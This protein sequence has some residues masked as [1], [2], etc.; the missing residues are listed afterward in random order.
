[1]E[2]CMAS[3]SEHSWASALRLTLH[4]KSTANE[5]LGKFIRIDSYIAFDLPIIGHKIRAKKCIGYTS[6]WRYFSGNKKFSG[7]Y[8]TLFN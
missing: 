1:M 5:N 2:A 3:L 8:G 6:I 4:K 7:P